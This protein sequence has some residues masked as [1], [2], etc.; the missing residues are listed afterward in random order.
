MVPFKEHPVFDKPFLGFLGFNIQEIRRA[1]KQVDP[2]APLFFVAMADEPMFKAVRAFYVPEAIVSMALRATT[3]LLRISKA[4]KTKLIDLS[5]QTILFY[6]NRPKMPLDDL[7]L[8]PS[9]ASSQSELGHL[10]SVRSLPCRS[11][12]WSRL[13][14]PSLLVSGPSSSCSVPKR[15][16]MAA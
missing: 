10:S 7:Y 4:C 1:A 6:P 5:H 2:H 13:T 3:P 8:S 9:A 12:L 15:L 14:G 11:G 16:F